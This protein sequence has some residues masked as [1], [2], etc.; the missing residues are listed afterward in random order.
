[1]GPRGISLEQFE[2]TKFTTDF[3]A[4]LESGSVTKT[5]TFFDDTSAERIPWVDWYKTI[6]GVDAKGNA[7][8]G[9]LKAE[10]AGLVINGST[11]SVYYTL[12]TKGAA[13]QKVGFKVSKS[14]GDW[15]IVSR[16]KD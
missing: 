6:A 3:K 8:E 10:V 5:L 7:S 14:D 9:A 16:E 4:A 12:E 13:P 15:Q 2:L 11:A 1:V